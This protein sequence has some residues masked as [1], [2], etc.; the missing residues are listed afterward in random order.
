V[1]G[2]PLSRMQTVGLITNGRGSMPGYASVL[3]ME[4]IEA[5]ADHILG[6]APSAG[7]EAPPPA[8][9]VAVQQEPAA[10]SAAPSGP[11]ETPPGL[12]A[13]DPG[14]TLGALPGESAHGRW[15]AAFLVGTLGLAA[16]VLWGRSLRNLTGWSKGQ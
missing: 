8:E 13:A 14:D 6:I 16:L 10:V 15:L 4:E 5:V 11:A 3:S 1:A 2:T 12:V 7:G 9:E